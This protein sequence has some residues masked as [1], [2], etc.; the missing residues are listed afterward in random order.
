MA[1]DK[2]PPAKNNPSNPTDPPVPPAGSNPVPDEP[3]APEHTG[4]TQ[5]IQGE[6]YIISI[7]INFPNDERS[8]NRTQNIVGW[9]GVAVSAI[10]AWF[11]YG[12]FSQASKQTGAAIHAA[13]TADSTYNEAKNYDTGSLGKQQRFFKEN[14]D[15]TKASA[16]SVDS[17]NRRVLAFYYKS[18]DS[19]SQFNKQ[20][21]NTADSS[22]QVQIDAIKKAQKNFEVQNE[23]YLQIK[24][25][26][27]DTFKVTGTYF[28]II[29]ETE[30]LSGYPA[31]IIDTKMAFEVCDTPPDSN[32]VKQ[33]GDFLLLI[34][35]YV[36]KES[37]LH[38]RFF[39]DSAQFDPHS[40][41][42]LKTGKFKVY[43][44]G[45]IRY[46]NLVTKAP[47]IYEFK[48]TMDPTP[49]AKGDFFYNENL[50]IPLADSTKD[51]RM[52]G[53]LDP[54]KL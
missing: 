9:A 52:V 30:N 8:G 21:L 26:I 22:L 32:R 5:Q 23:P 37:P 4:D 15:L 14:Y 6:P 18:L 34:N 47:R 40:D 24:S 46:I 13:N 20:T 51:I 19:S 12:L 3:Q 2:Q 17:N 33:S 16:D 39:E 53:W 36:I 1:D 11:T 29:F 50:D 35:S 44:W 7:N 45:Y 27:V 43:F 41:S 49:G 48:I 54:F 42:L 25:A 38:R 31:K 28:G 10:L